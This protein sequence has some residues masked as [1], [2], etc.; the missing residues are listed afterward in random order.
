[1]PVERSR[2]TSYTM[3]WKHLSNNLIV[4]G[5]EGGRYGSS[6]EVE[7]CLERI[8]RTTG[9]RFHHFKVS[10]KI[11]QLSRYI[12]QEHGYTATVA[13]VLSYMAMSRSMYFSYLQYLASW[14][15][16]YIIYGQLLLYI[17]LYVQGVQKVMTSK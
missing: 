17:Y 8:A 12:Q 3:I 13:I 16:S 7:E 9:G 5:R 11:R 4:P 10:G 1:M 6:E 15:G 2:F 14:H